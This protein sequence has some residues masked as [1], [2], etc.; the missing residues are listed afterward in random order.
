M[1]RLPVDPSVISIT[2]RFESFLYNYTGSNFF[3]EDTWFAI[4]GLMIPYNLAYR[5]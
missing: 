2:W 5:G 1:G 3:F 4:N